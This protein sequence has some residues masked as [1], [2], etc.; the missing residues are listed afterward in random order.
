MICSSF[1]SFFVFFLLVKSSEKLCAVVVGVLLDLLPVRQ[2]DLLHLTATRELHRYILPF[3][4]VVHVSM[5]KETNTTHSHPIALH[6]CLNTSRTHT[7]TKKLKL[8]IT[9]EEIEQGTVDIYTK[10]IKKKTCYRCH[11]SRRQCVTIFRS[12]FHILGNDL[13]EP[14]LSVYVCVEIEP[15]QRRIDQ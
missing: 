2:L 8:Y 10:N 9:N 1:R 3:D 14:T 11:Q 7:Q 5:Q 15:A 4:L 6:D 12:S 13:A